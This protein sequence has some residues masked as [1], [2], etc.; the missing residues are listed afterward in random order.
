MSGVYDAR[1]TPLLRHSTAADLALW[2][3]LWSEYTSKRREG[4]IKRKRA[5]RL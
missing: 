3:W 5:R 4:L 1:R 2:L